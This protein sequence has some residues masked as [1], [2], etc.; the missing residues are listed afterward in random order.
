[1]EVV[2]T[3]RTRVEPGEFVETSGFAEALQKLRAYSEIVLVDTPPILATSDAMAL[4]AKVD[5]ILLVTRLGTLTP[6]TLRELV[7]VL[8]RSPAPV[9][10][11]VA[12][13]AE[14][15]ETYSYYRVEEYATPIARSEGDES[16]GTDVQEVRSASAAGSGRW[17]PRR[18]G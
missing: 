4:T 12:T 1:L 15:D 3:G 10:G 8:G 14:L 2:T 17:T 18:G 16:A 11:F 13:G 6:P 9:L 5:A 7:R